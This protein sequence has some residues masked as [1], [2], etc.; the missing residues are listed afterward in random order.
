[1]F[2]KQSIWTVVLLSGPFVLLFNDMINFLA[3]ATFNSFTTAAFAVSYFFFIFFFYHSSLEPNSV[4]FR[5]NCISA[6]RQEDMFALS[7]RKKTLKISSKEAPGF[8]LGIVR[9]GKPIELL[10]LLMLTF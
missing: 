4:G 9:Q 1:M 10:Y 3:L 6:Q 8:L 5:K 2:F 7:E